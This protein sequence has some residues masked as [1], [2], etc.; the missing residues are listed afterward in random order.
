MASI[1]R[2]D[3]KPLFVHIHIP[4]TGGTSLNL[5]FE[6]WFGPGFR[7][8]YYPDPHYVLPHAAL[9]T[10]IRNEPSI[11]C[12]ASHSIRNFPSTI[13][14]RPT[15]YIAMMRE[16]HD[17]MLSVITH[18]RAEL[19]TFS[20]EHVRTLP[21]HADRLSAREFFQIRNE[22]IR[23]RIKQY[24]IGGSIGAN[25][26]MWQFLQNRSSPTLKAISLLPRSLRRTAWI[27]GLAIDAAI[28]QCRRELSSF[29]FVGDF[30][31]FQQ[32]VASLQRAMQAEGVRCALTR[33]PEA[34]VT[35]HL[36]TR[37]GPILA[38]DPVLVEFFKLRQADCIIYADVAVKKL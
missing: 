34:R 36:R 24:P 17:R 14:G 20:E 32:S 15:R 18:I 12:V 31:R 28:R 3:K 8:L 19:E 2:P 7:R 29:F 9:E 1:L 38:T 33:V 6:E 26:V 22:E 23:A 4:K 11:Q 5:L 37:V 30:H 21:P 25:V 27:R 16:P 13:A 10:L 35:R